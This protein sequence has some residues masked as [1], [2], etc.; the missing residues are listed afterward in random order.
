MTGFK[1][2]EGMTIHIKFTNS[3]SASNPK[4]KFNSE[5]NTNAKPIV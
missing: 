4:L 1:L 3:N 2:K 5:A